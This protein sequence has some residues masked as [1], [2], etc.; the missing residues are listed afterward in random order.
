MTR[1]DQLTVQQDVARRQVA[2]RDALEH[3]RQRGVADLAARLAQRGQRHRQQL[4][5]VDIVDPDQPDVVRAR[6]APSPISVRISRA[7][8]R[9]LAQTMPSGASDS[10]NCLTAAASSGSRR[11]TSAGSTGTSGGIERFAVAGCA[12]VDR[13]RGVGQRDEREPPGA[14]RQ[15]V[16]GDDVAGAAVVDADEVVMAALG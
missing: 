7:A 10:I 3:R 2:P 9:S 16:L 8:V 1:D 4:G 14:E 11:C 5:E 6:D 15:Q 12:R 13:R